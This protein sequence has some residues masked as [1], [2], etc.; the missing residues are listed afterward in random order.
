MMGGWFLAS[1]IGNKLSGVAGELYYETGHVTF[2]AV[3][4]ACL[5]A[6]ALLIALMV[7][8]LRRQLGEDRKPAA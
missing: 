3:N 4:A 2:F 8:W 7:P 6:A 5:G 1:A